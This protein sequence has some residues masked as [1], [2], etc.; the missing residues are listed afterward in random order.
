MRKIRKRA[1]RKSR[2]PRQHGLRSRRPSKRM[3]PTSFI[4]IVVTLILAAFGLL[5]IFEASA[6]SA[7]R[8][9]DDK[10]HFLRNQ[11]M[12]AGIG[13]VAMSV[14]SK[15]DYRRYYSMSIFMLGAVIISLIMVFLPGV[16]VK[17]SGAH[18][19]INL[20]FFSFQPTSLA[21]LVLVI[22]LAAW[23]THKEKSRLVSFLLL[24][25][26]VLGLIILEPDLGTAII[27]GS[28]AVVLYFLSGA[29]LVQFLALLPMG[30]VS[31]LL[32]GLSSPYRYKR[33]LTFLNPNSD[34]LGSSYHVQ[35]LLLG[36]GSGGWFGVGL[37]RS[38]QK[39]SY[40]PEAMTDS[41]FSIVGEE[42]GFLG[43]SLVLLLYLTLIVLAFKI[44]VNAPTRF[45][46]LLAAGIAS[47]IAIQTII[48][49]GA[50]VALLPLTGVPLM[51]LSYGGSSLLVTFLG[52]G[53][54]LN[55][56]NQSK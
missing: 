30:I 37:G 17:V 25:F 16:G 24:L 8:T 32:L 29:P 35:Q 7:L 2:T 56:S 26:I 43:A 21:K 50:A 18:R 31:V 10:F 54:L 14:V 3:N 33:L 48:N 19:W 41:I 51:L 13:M 28:I 47:W 36:F 4:L 15:I 27:I 55:I 12:W 9:F 20:G 40:L 6:I 11:G 49:L 34:P 46:Q 22:Y 44:A 39:F 52:I 23:F 38:R 42:T 45:G 5:M 53:V 1:I